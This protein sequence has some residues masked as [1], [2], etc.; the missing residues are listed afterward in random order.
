MGSVL[1][2]NI[3]RMI[4]LIL[5]QCLILIRI[6]LSIGSFD[7]MNIILVHLFVLLLPLNTPRWTILLLAFVCGVS[8]DLFYDSPGVHAS[9]MVF[10]AYLR[11]PVLKFLEPQGGYNVNEIPSLYHFDFSWIVIYTSILTFAYMIWY[12][13]MVSF[14]FVF[15]LDI[16]LST[17]F[18]FII[19]VVILLVYQFIFRPKT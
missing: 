16:I 2:R 4:M 9:A 11:K 5:I 13:S 17:I 19:S 1:F 7:Y 8:V 18:S 6:D 10:M 14:S 3:V 12:F 15:F